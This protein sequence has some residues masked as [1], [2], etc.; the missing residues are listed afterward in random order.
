VTH[1]ADGKFQFGWVIRVLSK[2]E[3]GIQ[4]EDADLGNGKH[5]LVA[6]DFSHPVQDNVYRQAGFGP[7]PSPRSVFEAP[8]AAFESPIRVLKAH[9][10][11]LRADLEKERLA[12]PTI[13]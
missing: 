3:D 1:M 7:F 2:D 6:T 8:D 4:I 12:F 9:L 5:M 11:K 13:L 10:L